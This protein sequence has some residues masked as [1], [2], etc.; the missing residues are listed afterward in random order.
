MLLSR[1][2]LIATVF[3]ET[4]RVQRMKMPLA[5][6]LFGIDDG[7]RWRARG[8]AEVEDEVVQILV[9]RMT[10][11]LRCYDSIGRYGEGEFVLVLPGCSSFN[12]VS[13]AA[14]LRL[15]VLGP[16][17]V[18]RNE[19]MLFTAC[20][21]VAGSGGRSALVVLRNGEQAL[22]KARARGPG[23]I[24]RCTYDTEPDPAMFLMPVIEDEALHW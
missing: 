5:L 16:A 4:D 3:R 8:G 17:F 1:D 14:R 19:E 22:E 12:A 18:V 23:S 13:L 20:F 11:L 10:R 9:K 24:E 2:E 6:I 15:E 21:G 7:E